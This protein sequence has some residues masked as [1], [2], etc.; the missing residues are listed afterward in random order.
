M[1]RIKNVRNATVAK[2]NQF[3]PVHA[4][5]PPPPPPLKLRRVPTPPQSKKA[6]KVQ[7]RPSSRVQVPHFDHKVT[8]VTKT[9]AQEQFFSK[10]V[11]EWCGKSGK[12]NP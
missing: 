1:F 3:S 8:L 5:R 10:K 4:P 11:P 9:H 2:Q 7:A 12:A 6:P